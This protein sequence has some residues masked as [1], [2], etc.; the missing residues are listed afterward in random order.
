MTYIKITGG[1][2]FANFKFEDILI[3]EDINVTITEIKNYV[4]KIARNK[5]NSFLFNKI[6]LWK[7]TEQEYEDYLKAALYYNF[8]ILSE[9]E[10]AD[11]CEQE[12]Y[13]NKPS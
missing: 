1:H 11:F 12:V 13:K 3:I 7:G 4:Y 10:Y 6:G 8:K 9:K 2:A 5:I